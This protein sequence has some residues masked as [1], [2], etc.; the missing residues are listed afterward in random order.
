MFSELFSRRQ[1]TEILKWV[2]YS[3]LFLLSMLLQTIVLPRLTIGGIA[4][5]AVPTC[6]VCVAVREGAD[7]LP[8]THCS[9]A[10]SSA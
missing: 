1:L 7:R 10:P 8:F 2:L 4:L 5:C 3:I 9:A 6:V